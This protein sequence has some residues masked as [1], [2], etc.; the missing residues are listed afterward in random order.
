MKKILLANIGNRN[1]YVEDTNGYFTTIDRYVSDKRLMQYIEITERNL[2]E[3]VLFK[4]FTEDLWNKII[5]KQP[6]LSLQ[7]EILTA[8]VVQQDGYGQVVIFF[9]QQED[10]KF[11]HQDTVYEALIIEHLL[12]KEFPQIEVRLL[13]IDG[14][15]TDENNL[16]EHYAVQIKELIKKNP[17]S[18]FAYLD[19]GGTTQMK[20]AAKI[21]FDYYLKQYQN[22]LQ[23]RY[24]NYLQDYSE[25]VERRLFNQYYALD[26]ASEFINAYD[27]ESAFQTLSRIST[28]SDNI[29]SIILHT[30]IAANRLAFNNRKRWH[31]HLNDGTKLQA[32]AEQYIRGKVPNGFLNYPELASSKTELFEFA[33]I[34]QH[35]FLTQNY[36]LGVATYYRLCEEIGKTYAEKIMRIDLDPESNRKQF[37]NQTQND[38]I[39]YLPSFGSQKYGI[40]YLIAFAHADSLSRHSS[41]HSIIDSI[42]PTISHV[43][44]LQSGKGINMLRNRCWLAHNSLSIEKADI[45]AEVN[46]FLQKHLPQIF[47]TL[48]MPVKNI[49]EEIRQNL[50]TML[51]E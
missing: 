44:L 34:C 47:K 45:D 1:L 41:A 22:N 8:K 39:G 9:T 25:N 31:I 51:K 6:H 21:V 37:V 14:N 50:L 10:E 5:D 48:G 33:S 2:T 4:K 24:I 36:T 11:N 7:L 18:S 27:F 15:P 16:F 20:Y 29:L 43:N 28:P 35:Y 3:K 42:R 30:N 12:K 32:I 19:A 23:I 46:G 38:I 17:D 13:K 26:L 40:P 49:F